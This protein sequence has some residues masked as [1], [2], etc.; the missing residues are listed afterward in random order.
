MTMFINR[1]ADYDPIY[2]PAY[3]IQALNTAAS[4]GTYAMK[5]IRDYSGEE[6]NLI[7]LATFNSD[8]M[9][10]TETNTSADTQIKES[11]QMTVVIA[12]NIPSAPSAARNIISCFTPN[13]APW[14]GFRLTQGTDGSGTIRVGSGVTGTDSTSLSIGGI[15][16]GWT[17]FAFTVSNSAISFLRANGTAGSTEITVGRGLST[18]NIFIN[19]A[20]P[21]SPLLTGIDGT[22][23]GVAV[24]SAQLSLSGM[25][26]QI[27]NMRTFMATKG[28]VIP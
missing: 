27:N 20:P 18:N 10:C 4:E 13:A 9:I 21:T 23:G 17:S 28:V 14:F 24:Y 12:L 3:P 25:T 19:G 15:T 1:V 7:T 16:G 8:G 26:L 6:H 11:E 5:S 22:I 2:P